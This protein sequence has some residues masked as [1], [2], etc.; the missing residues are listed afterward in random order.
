MNHGVS[1]IPDVPN[2]IHKFV[3]YACSPAQRRPFAIR[4]FNVFVLYKLP[5]FDHRPN[6]KLFHPI[7]FWSL[8]A[9]CIPCMLGKS[10]LLIV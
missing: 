3:D 6:I 8:I 4:S 5:F 1:K 7:V 9:S 10:S 2:H